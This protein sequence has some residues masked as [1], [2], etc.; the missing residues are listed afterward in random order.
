MTDPVTVTKPKPLPRRPSLAS[1]RFGYVVA[2]LVNVALLVVVNNIL[3]WD[4]LRFLTRDF[5]RVIPI[6][7]VSLG[8][9]ILA[10]LVYLSYDAPWFKSL[11]QIGLLG[12]SMAVT[13]RMYRVFPFD[14][15]RYE[16]DWTTVAKVVLILAM[17]GVGLGILAE[18]VKL[19]T[20]R[21]GS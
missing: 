18:F 11:A 20:R 1:R 5:E 12:I 14:F 2:V 15:S 21:G 19:A 17:V 16:F 9:S 6:L 10:N 4:I 8:A 7:N 3:D 13:V